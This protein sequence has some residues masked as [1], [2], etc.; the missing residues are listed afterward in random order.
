MG[1][2]GGFSKS[3]LLAQR[4]VPVP[5]VSELRTRSDSFHGVL[6]SQLVQVF[7]KSHQTPACVLGELHPCRQLDEHWMSPHS[8]VTHTEG[9]PCTCWGQKRPWQTRPR[10]GSHAFE[11]ISSCQQWVFSHFCNVIP[12]YSEGGAVTNINRRDMVR[13]ELYKHSL[14]WKF[15]LPRP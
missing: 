1:V 10:S 7:N 13:M 14:L 3:I 8:S 2:F 11:Q 9:R 6:R 4:F 12:S 15:L 5:R